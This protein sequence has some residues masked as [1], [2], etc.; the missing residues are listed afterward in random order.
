MEARERFRSCFSSAPP[1]AFPGA[2]SNDLPN[3][4]RAW[5]KDLVRR[6][7]EPWGSFERFDECFSDLFRYFSRPDSWSLFPEAVET[8]SALR[9]QGL[10]LAVISNFDSRLFGILDGLGIDSWFHSIFIS[11]RVG[12]AKP[13]PEIFRAALELYRLKAAETLHIGDSPEKDAAGANNAGLTG[14][15]L[16][17]NGRSR[18]DSLLRVRDLR[19]ILT[20]V[21]R[22]S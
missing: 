8:L 9:G 2:S 6:V 17:R 4:E 15:L 18:M 1:I 21:E 19:E 12:Y 10:I 5:W 20:L 3:L 22:Q 14:V 11:S 13:A 16:D 7:F